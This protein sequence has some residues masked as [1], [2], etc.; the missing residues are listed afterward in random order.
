MKAGKLRSMF[1]A[2]IYAALWTSVTVMIPTTAHAVKGHCEGNT[3]WSCSTYSTS[4]ENGA[5]YDAKT[6]QWYNKSCK[7]QEDSGTNGE[8]GAYGHAEIHRKN[9]PTVKPS[10]GIGPMDASRRPV[11]IAPHAPQWRAR[12]A[13]GF[14]GERAF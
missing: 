4:K 5:W 2:S 12:P 11:W 9:V 3:H 1:A 7:C 6:G 14:R 13:A 8:P 10:G